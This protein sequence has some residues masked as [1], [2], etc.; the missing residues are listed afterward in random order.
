M[1]R[2][3]PW[4]IAGAVVGVLIAV[5]LLVWFSV[6]GWWPIVLDITII[7]TCIVSL[8]MIGFLGAAV[9]YL[10][11]TLLRVKREMMPVLESLRHTSQAV[12]DTARVAS[13]LG[14]AP[15]VR[16]AS[17]LVGAAEA[18][19]LVLGRGHARTRQ[20]RRQQRRQEVERELQARGELN[21]HR[22]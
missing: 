12:S 4:L 7:V 16:T 20:Q 8:L 1:K 2:Y 19:A 18:A 6:A 9:F 5:G 21:G 11:I 22:G 10:A 13:D 14:V 3:L 17:V 15:T